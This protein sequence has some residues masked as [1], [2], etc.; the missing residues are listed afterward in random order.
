MSLVLHA[1]R[2]SHVL[3]GLW[4]L[5]P[6]TQHFELVIVVAEWAV[7]GFVDTRLDYL[8]LELH[9]AEVAQWTSLGFVDTGFGLRA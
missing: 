3:S 4:G 5:T 2:N 6:C 7:A 1:S 9:G 8:L